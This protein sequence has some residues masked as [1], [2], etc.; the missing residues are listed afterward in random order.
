LLTIWRQTADMSFHARQPR[1]AVTVYLH[2]MV[3]PRGST[4]LV[5]HVEPLRVAV[6]QTMAE[7]PFRIEAWVTLPDELHAIWRLPDDDADWAARWTAITARFARH[8]SAACQMSGKGP[9]QP[10]VTWQSGTERPL[11]DVADLQN[12]RDLCWTSPVLA[13]L[14]QG[15][16]DW[17]FSSI[18]RDLP[19]ALG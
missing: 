19:A 6:R 17:P 4:V 7:R 18:H 2:Q 13:G 12:H 5:D 16:W 3:K 10:G 15:P 8:L 9:G 1:P 14:V 11:R